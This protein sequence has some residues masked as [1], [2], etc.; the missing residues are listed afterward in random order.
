[1]DLLSFDHFFYWIVCLIPIGLQV[2]FIFL[3]ITI[4]SLICVTNS[5]FKFIAH[6]FTFFMAYF[7]Q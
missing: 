5:T 6:L 2:F 1:M 3:D 4:L 7:Y